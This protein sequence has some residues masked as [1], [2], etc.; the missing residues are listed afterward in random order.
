MYV[1]TFYSFK[2]GVGRT[3]ALVNTAATLAADGRRVLVVDFDLEAPGITT[4]NIFSAATNTPGVV[5]YITNYLSSD[6]APDVCDYISHCWTS[7]DGR[8]EIHV[9]SA[10]LRDSAYARRLTSIDWQDL[11]LNR[12]G[13]LLL[14]DLKQ[15]W[16]SHSASFDYILIDSRTGHTDVGGI[17]TRQLPDT[18]VLMFFPNQQNL[19]GIETVVSDIRR[20][21]TKVE[22]P[23]K[24]LFCPS[25]V[26]NLD[27]EESLLKLQ[28]GEA[29]RIL[30]FKKPDAVIRHY[31][32][33]SLIS[34]P[35]FVLDRS[36]TRLAREYIQLSKA[37]VRTNIKDRNGA[38]SIILSAKKGRS[39]FGVE[40][41]EI[42]NSNYMDPQEILEQIKEIEKFHSK[43]GEISWALAPIYHGLGDLPSEYNA[44]TVA[45]QAGFKVD[46]ARYRRAMNMLGSGQASDAVA[47]LHHILGSTS[48]NFSNVS[49]AIQLLRANDKDWVQSVRTSVAVERLKPRERFQIVLLLNTE[50][51]ALRLGLT[52]LRQMALD[53]DSTDL[54]SSIKST[55][56]LNLIGLQEF[57]EAIE[58]YEIDRTSIFV[59]PIPAAFNYAMAEWGMTGRVPVDIIDYVVAR[60]IGS[61]SRDAN[62]HQCLSLVLALIGENDKSL[63]RLEQARSSVSVGTVFSCWRYMQ[64]DRKGMLSD[65]DAQQQ[66]IKDIQLEADVLSLSSKPL[67]LVKAH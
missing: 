15:Q 66:F 44:L 34:Q 8:G 37:I 36:G 24:L 60:D 20:E 47:D 10:G 45:I 25:N 52:M 64:V 33:L 22:C 4:F 23:I 67:F 26:P 53:I 27:D 62:Y 51:K 50:A 38:L 21:G 63:E 14:E 11:Y 35:V 46:S 40:I 17:C 9:M 43:D 31:D 54:M 41:D 7:E 58:A 29:S 57:E 5:D 65:L 18:V 16:E 49:A 2:G 1:V 6:T 61:N 28:L 48:A 32:S 42:Q 39:V 59:K 12:D 3:M 55:R 56:I 19:L 13:Y 30:D